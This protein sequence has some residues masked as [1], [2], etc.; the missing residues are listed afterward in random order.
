MK[1]FINTKIIRINKY[2]SMIIYTTIIH[3]VQATFCNMYV[4]EYKSNE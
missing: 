3:N 1:Q 2:L 4:Y